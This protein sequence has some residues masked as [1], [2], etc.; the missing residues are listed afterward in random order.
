MM[1]RCVA[2]P[3]DAGIIS[4]DHFEVAGEDA[5]GIEQ[6]AELGEVE[7]PTHSSPDVLDSA[8]QCYSAQPPGYEHD[9]L[10]FR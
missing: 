10:R 3:D 9:E 1:R 4:A 2:E 8:E 5:G 7:V 6:D